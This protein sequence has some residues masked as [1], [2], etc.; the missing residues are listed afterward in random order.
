MP[1]ILTFSVIDIS[2]PSNSHAVLQ[3]ILLQYLSHHASLPQFNLFKCLKVYTS[4][5]ILGIFKYVLKMQNM[6][7]SVSLGRL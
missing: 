5:S 1:P 7:L 6:K 3:K 2:T 4:V